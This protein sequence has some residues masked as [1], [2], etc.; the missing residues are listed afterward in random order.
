MARSH[1]QFAAPGSLP[2]P[3]DLGAFGMTPGCNL[4]VEALDTFLIINTGRGFEDWTV[5]VP[6]QPNLLGLGL[7][8]QVLVLDSAAGNRLGAVLSDAASGAV[9]L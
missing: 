1:N 5:P 6:N 9:G 2:L 3:V 8:N 4:R 7:Y